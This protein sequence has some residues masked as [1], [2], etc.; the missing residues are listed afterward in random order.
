MTAAARRI[1]L[2]VGCP[3]TGTTYLQ[4]TLWRSRESLR[5]LDVELPLDRVSHFHLALAVRD[6]LDPEMDS[7]PAHRVLDRLAEALAESTAT[8]IVISNENL[9]RASAE[10]AARLWELV[11]GATPGAESHLVITA[12]DLARQVPAEWQQQIQHRRTIGWPRFLRSL[13][14]GTEPAAYFLP[15]QDASDVALRWGGDLPADRV[16]LVTV[17]RPGAPKSLLLE[18]FCTVLGIDPAAVADSV[19]DA[20]ESLGRAPLELLRRV[21]VALDERLAHPRAGFGR[22]GKRYFAYEVLAPMGGDR[23]VLPA[24]MAPWCE[25]QSE[26]LVKRLS[27]AGYDVVGDLDELRPELGGLEAEPPAVTDTE[28]AAAAVAAL[29]DVLD[30]RH[31]DLDEIERL[32]ERLRTLRARKR[33][34]Q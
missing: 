21:N 24:E 11:R 8:T 28:I 31:R 18:R 12:R 10:Q 20:N 26:R 4:S 19:P 33:R 6:Q 1:F 13:R 2:H 14:D 30:Q 15:S 23:P 29:A 22:V 3:K 7:A 27:T 9:A 17:P 5:G 25:A 34:P 32:R 16:H